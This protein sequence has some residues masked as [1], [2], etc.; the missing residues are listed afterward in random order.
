MISVVLQKYYQII[1]RG[2]KAYLIL[3]AQT[4]Y[5]FFFVFF[6]LLI[7]IDSY[8]YIS[9]LSFAMLSDSLKI[10][11]GANIDMANLLIYPNSKKTLFLSL[12]AKSFFSE[13]I[14]LLL[15]FLIVVNISLHFHPSIS[16]LLLVIYVI[17]CL[18]SVIIDIQARRKAYISIIFKNISQ[19]TILLVFPFII[20]SLNPSTIEWKGITE[21]MATMLSATHYLIAISLIGLSSMLSYYTFKKTYLNSPFIDSRIVKN[22]NKNYWY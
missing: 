21:S 15:S 1:T 10:R 7:D 19:L 22:F 13:K 8:F 17:Y 11:S 20:N 3:F 9:L 6:G 18:I 12:F 14:I 4:F 5:L 2:D 16:F